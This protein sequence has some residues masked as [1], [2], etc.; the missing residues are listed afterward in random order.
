[1][2]ARQEEDRHQGQRD[3]VVRHQRQV[4]D[5]GE[6]IDRQIDAGLREEPV[7]HLPLAEPA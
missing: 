3:V 6:D 2:V 7:D 1:M 4:Q 5:G